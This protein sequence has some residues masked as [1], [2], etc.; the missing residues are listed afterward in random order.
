M[1]EVLNRIQEYSLEDIMGQ[2]FG[3]YAKYIIQ[4][5]AIPDVRDGLKPVQRRI[6]YAM[7]KAHNTYEKST[8]KSATTVGDVIG[9]YHPH[10]DSSVYGAMVRM[11][12][13]WVYAHP[14]INFQGNNGS[15]DGD[16]AAAYRYTEAKL[17]KISNELLKDLDKD[18]VVFAPTFDDARMEPTVLPS[19]FPNLL[20]NGTTGISA[21]YATNIPT[22]NLG[23]VIDATIK[24]IDS[25]N[26]RLD[27]ILE[28]V[29]GPDFPTGGIIEGKD[30]IRKSYETGKGKFVVKAKYSFEKV[31]GK[32]SIVITEIPYEVTLTSIVKKIE[33]IRID[34]KID[35]IVEARNETGKEGIRIVIDLKPGANKDLIINYLLKNTDMQV[36]Y[37]VNMVAVVNRRP[38]QLGI[39]QILDAYIEHQ[40]DVVKRRTKFELATYNKE[41][42]ILEGLIKALSILDELIKVIRASKNKADAKINIINKFGFTEEQAEAIVTLQLYRL[43]NTDVIE[44]E[45]RHKEL[46]LLISECNKILADENELMSV[47]KRELREIKKEFAIPRRTEIKDEITEIK[48]DKEAMINKDD[49]VVTLTKAGYIKKMSIKAFNANDEDLPVKD[50]DYIIGLYKINNINTVLAFTDKGNYLYIPVYEI[51]ETKFKDL[52]KHVNTI[53]SLPDDENIISCYPVTTFKTNKIVT[54]FTKDGACKRANLSDFEVSRY[55]KPVTMMKIKDSDKVTSAFVSDAKEVLCVTKNGYGLRFN[56]DEISIVGLKASG[57]KGIKLTNDELVSAVPIV[58]EE[59]I[60][61]ITNNGNAKRV[62][63][64][65]IESSNRAKKGTAIIKSPKAK[66]YDVLKVFNN[67]T[68]DTIGILSY[69][70]L[71]EVKTSEIP[72]FDIKSVGSSISKRELTD[73]FIFTKFE[74]VKNEEELTEVENKEVINNEVKTKELKEEKTD[75][76]VYEELTMSDFFDEFK[77]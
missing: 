5:R 59:Y 39:L 1:S 15:V 41:M 62:K 57:V 13:S 49:Y 22:H 26:C 52:G 4:D 32:E 23:E 21:G 44:L 46:E 10:G 70:K 75:E 30:E 63:L 61:L 77:L 3:R 55:T 50:G 38:K 69:D 67:E 64:S 51:E 12:Q 29:K 72:F 19:R 37:S 74:K 65:E 73:S 24:R 48:V 53:V 14:L 9:R 45:N 58:N 18:T 8:V 7:Y 47:I 40:K 28:I 42:H 60:T 31:K 71:F 25:P 20:V 35:G 36:N 54:I 2:R 76:P 66:K 17:S 43:T 33:D 6:L 16:P 56:L 27:S 34:K 68:K 11:S